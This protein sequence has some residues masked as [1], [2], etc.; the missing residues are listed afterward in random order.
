[1]SRYYIE[2]AGVR[3]YD[4]KRT[5]AHLEHKGK[6]KYGD[7]FKLYDLD[8]E[9]I[10]RLLLHAIQDS[11]SCLENNIDP[12]KGILLIGPVGSGKT[13]LMTLLRDFTHPANRYLMKST[14]DIAAEYHTEGYPIIQ[15]YSKAHK[16]YCLDDL[17]VEQN[18]KQY[19]N[20]CNTMAE[21]LLNRYELFVNHGIQ[22]HA[23]T[24]LNADDLETIYGNRVRS[25]FRSMFNLIDFPID[26][27]DKR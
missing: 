10:Y 14:R 13:A 20:E 24:N 4:R 11:E 21:I 6:V 8:Q 17:G 25:R 23:T 2:E 15:K 18:V 26:S 5:I 3:Y 7:Q 9:N 19:G 1:M 12:K 27:P 16:W 22:T